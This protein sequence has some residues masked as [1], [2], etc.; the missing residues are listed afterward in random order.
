MTVLNT[1]PWSQ[2]LPLWLYSQGSG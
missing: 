2:H 1:L